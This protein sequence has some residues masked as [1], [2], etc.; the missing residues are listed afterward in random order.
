MSGASL[1][2]RRRRFLLSAAALAAWPRLART[3]EAHTVNDVSQLNPVRVAGERRPRSTE[4]VQEIVRGSRGPISIGGARYS[5]G[6]Q[7]AEPRSVHVDTR[8]MNAVLRLDAQTRVIRVQAGA[9]WR[10]VQDVIDPLGLSVRIMQSYSNFTVGGSIG[11]NCHGRYVGRGPL[12]NALRSLRVVTARGEA[13]E[14]SR[15]SNADL[16]RAVVGGYGGL[17]IVTEAELDLGSN[18]RI[19]KIVRDV[20]L[21]DYPAWFHS[22][23]A[24]NPH[25]VLHNADLVPPRFATPRAITWVR[26]DKPLTREERLVPR[27]LPYEHEQNAIWAI[28]ELPGGGFLRHA[29]AQR[30]RREPAVV[31]QNY[32]ASLDTASLEPR[33]RRF[34]TYLLQEYFIPVERFTAFARVLAHV[35]AAANVQALNVSIRHSPADTVS[36]LRWAPG[37][38]FSF[39][40]YYKQATTRSADLDAERWT[41]ALVS[42]ALQNGGRHY[43]P[44]RLHATREQFARAYPEHRTFARIKAE[45]DPQR[46]FRNLLWDKY[47]PR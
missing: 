7:I 5:M 27:G 26:S 24:A 10:D 36:L 17:G 31:W 6:G 1:R 29:E 45:Y 34:S 15:G 40:L 37:E 8:A 9:T 18:L 41:Q 12:V 14:A 19:G 33:S 46:R 21:D 30:A 20:P 25:A 23:V 4:D 42:A 44:Y 32:E 11:V 16:F 38:V 2:T 35:L 13:I 22:E 39:V 28:T 3:A 47:L 43:L